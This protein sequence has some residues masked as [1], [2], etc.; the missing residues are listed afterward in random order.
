MTSLALNLGHS[1]SS[2][3]AQVGHL[4]AQKSVLESLVQRLRSGVGEEEVERE[5]EMVG[6]RRGEEEREEERVEWGEVLFG[7][8]G[9]KWEEEKDETD[10]EKGT[11][12]VDGVGERAGT[13]GGRSVPGGGC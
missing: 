3:A 13:D 9:K 11:L 10:W 7:K 2:H 8:R 1:R 12:R 6:L 5:L 4:E